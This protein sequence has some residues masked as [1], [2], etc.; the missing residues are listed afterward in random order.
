MDW[1]ASGSAAASE[2]QRPLPAMKST[3]QYRPLHLVAILGGM[4]VLLVVSGCHTAN[5]FGKD[6]ERVGEKIQSGT[7]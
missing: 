4:L 7:K 2:H 5:G 6:V 3:H 1:V